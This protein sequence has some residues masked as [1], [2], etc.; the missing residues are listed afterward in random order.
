MA[1]SSIFNSLEDDD[2][3]K[4]K[5]AIDL[6]GGSS[7]TEAYQKRIFN[8]EKADTFKAED[9]AKIAKT[10]NRFGNLKER[11]G[12][13]LSRRFGK[14]DDTTELKSIGESIKE[15][16]SKQGFVTEAV[17]NW[18]QNK[19]QKRQE[20]F[21]NTFLDIEQAKKDLDDEV[22]RI[23]GRIASQGQP[24]RDMGKPLTLKEETKKLE[25][26]VSLMGGKDQLENK[27]AVKRGTFEGDIAETQQLADL[28]QEN[29]ETLQLL[30]EYSGEVETKGGFL[31]GLT[32]AMKDPEEAYKTFVPFGGDIYATLETV[33]DAK[34]INKIYNKI[35]NGEKLTITERAFYQEYKNQILSEMIKK[36]VGYEIGK[37]IASLPK[38]ALEF[39]I[40][41]GIAT[42][43]AKGL[44]RVGTKSA[45]T[46]TLETASKAGV[47]K[48]IGTISRKEAKEIGVDLVRSSIAN[49]GR[50]GIGF[51]P[52]V[53]RK[54]AEF[55][56]DDM[57][58]LQGENGDLVVQKVGEG[59]SFW[60]ALAK[61]Y[62][63]TY[64]EVGA[65]SVGI[66]ANVPLARTKSGVMGILGRHITEPDK[67]LQKAILAKFATKRGLVSSESISKLAS[68]VGWNG[69]IE[70]VF[71]EE[72]TELLQAP[73]EE[74]KYYAPWTPQGME[75]L[76]VETLAIGA[77]GGL[78]R[79]AQA[80]IPTGR[81][82]TT[83][84]KGEEETT[85]KPTDDDMVF[86]LEKE[87]VVVSDK[88]E[89]DTKTVEQE[90]PQE[91]MGE[92]TLQSIPS[93]LEDLVQEAQQMD[94]KEFSEK[95][96]YLFEGVANV[97]STYSFNGTAE[98]FYDTA[99]KYP[100]IET[101]EA[102]ESEPTKDE[103]NEV[104]KPAKVE[105]M[106]N[107]KQDPLIEEAR[108]Y[109]SA[110]EFVKAQGDVL[111]HGTPAKFDTKD[112]KGGYLTADKSYA[113]VYKNPS[114]S[115]ISYGSAGIQNKLSGEPRTLEFVLPKKAKIFD[116]TNPQ[117]RKL[118]D[119]Y[120]GK[121][122]MS[123]DPV[124]G[125]SGQLDWTE[126]ENLVEYFDEKGIKFDGIKL[127][128]AGGIDPSSGLEVKRSPSIRIINPKILKDK[129]QLTDLYNQAKAEVPIIDR[130]QLTGKA[131]STPTDPL[132]ALKV[133]ARK[134]K[135]AEEFVKAQQKKYVGAS[136]KIDM[137]EDIEVEDSY[138]RVFGDIDSINKEIED[139]NY[140]KSSYT[141]EDF[142]E[143]GKEV[144]DVFYDSYEDFY[145]DVDAD[146]RDME[147]SLADYV[148]KQRKIEDEAIWEWVDKNGEWLGNKRGVIADAIDEN[149]RTGGTAWRALIE[150]TSIEDARDMLGRLEV[151][152]KRHSRTNYDNTSKSGM[153]EDEVSK[154]RGE[155]NADLY[156]GELDPVMET[157]R[158][159]EI[160]IRA[161][162]QGASGSKREKAPSLSGSPSMQPQQ[163]KSI[164]GREF[165][166][167]M[168]K[169]SL[170][171]NKR[172]LQQDGREVKPIL[173]TN[174]GKVEEVKTQPKI[175]T[176]KKTITVAEN[177]TPIGKEEE[178]VS[179]LEARVKGMLGDMTTDE[180]K[181]IG[182][183]TYNRMNQE[184]DIKETTGFVLEDIDRAIRILRG[185]EDAPKGRLYGSIYV[186]LHNIANDRPELA[187]QLAMGTAAQTQRST[188]A[189][190]EIS[191]LQQ[192]DP[193]S[194]LSLI[195]ELE[196]YRIA[197]KGGL[198][199]NKDKGGAK[200]EK[201]LAEID[202]IIGK[203]TSKADTDVFMK[204]IQDLKC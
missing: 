65:E 71:E 193:F 161:N 81:I 122:S 148:D 146:I 38:Y 116:Y 74:R 45:L 61:A 85:Q 88:V 13:S 66:L 153:S 117:H 17:D 97:D 189:G 58:L 120:W 192:I 103:L 27:G 80:P 99:M 181:E 41:G 31:S 44:G 4:K 46:K 39:A 72:T 18:Q 149:R 130:T 201:E 60:K 144:D 198:F 28:L 70:E 84:G 172:I 95:Y 183:T 16:P 187:L 29:K 173:K 142:A 202:R 21:R 62:A 100:T 151:S 42:G 49:A 106:N 6:I 129:S 57:A 188:R 175:K 170:G 90:L 73:I 140:K 199:S 12:M 48:T 78:A 166:S 169:T 20:T 107:P 35:A 165:S 43:I 3:K 56:S 136:T 19:E 47:R 51:A 113:D 147:G 10:K 168:K 24:L 52:T 178:K 164:G 177:I 204:F 154:L 112:F 25:K 159:A 92:D 63:S 185:A 145:K 96:G 77:F 40:T 108:K 15:I 179:R 182:L 186:A 53:S 69:V 125:K 109:K 54:T 118:L 123:Y 55:M 135:T 83:G 119:D 98:E 180:A 141:D 68:K 75:R 128:E 87:G 167:T 110:E 126:G 195:N 132:E 94:K 156:D 139:L 37:T 137:L 124:V 160:W 8:R 191:I 105:A 150:A 197:T 115:S 163:I 101:E 190:Q 9:D 1:R 50:T 30:K 127:D 143:N 104:L 111:Y 89:A 2:R 174:K 7:E 157:E 155:F 5:R 67:F 200:I 33:H 158:L 138:G 59:D 134:Y 11:L 194:T 76:L 152:S 23:Q 26:K 162:T 32:S 114:A 184:Q 64:V 171:R 34:E 121:S 102:P 133:E 176:K 91:A 131:L 86:D 79:V 82:D 22:L 93:Q 196:S 203:E 14:R 36:G